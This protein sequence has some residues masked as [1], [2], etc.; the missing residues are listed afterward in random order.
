MTVIGIIGTVEYLEAQTT[1]ILTLKQ[2]GDTPD[3]GDFDMYI[4]PENNRNYWYSGHRPNDTLTSTEHDD[5]PRIGHIFVPGPRIPLEPN[6]ILLESF[7]TTKGCT[8]NIETM[9][10]ILDPNSDDPKNQVKNIAIPSNIKEQTNDTIIAIG[11]NWIYPSPPD[12]KWPCTADLEA[13]SKQPLFLT[14]ELQYTLYNQSDNKAY[15]FSPRENILQA[16]P[17]PLCTNSTIDTTTQSLKGDTKMCYGKN[18]ND[19][20]I[21]T[22]KLTGFYGATETI[23]TPTIKRNL[24]ADRVDDPDYLALLERLYLP[25]I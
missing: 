25:P 15:H 24:D 18:G 21:M 22:K 17:I 16:Q 11:L 23:T 12:D 3:F 7:N 14:K 1:T 8:G 10:E 13:P 4:N 5:Y 9:K 20:I 6:P 2:M 19:M